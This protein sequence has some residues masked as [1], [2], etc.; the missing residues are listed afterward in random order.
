MRTIRNAS[1]LVSM[2]SKTKNN[3]RHG[4]LRCRQ[5]PCDLGEVVDMSA[6]GM[7]MKS[8]RAPKVGLGDVV[9]VTLHYPL[10]DLP[11]RARVV[12]MKKLAYRSYEIGLEFEQV[13]PAIK[14]SLSV[15]VQTATDRH[16]GRSA[17]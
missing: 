3:R 10:G 1:P 16:G 2:S 6:S 15:V 7:K 9:S 17:A 5:L 14:A 8:S 12:W 11:I 13:T 4:R